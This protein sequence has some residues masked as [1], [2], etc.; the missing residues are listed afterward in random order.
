MEERGKR[1]NNGEIDDKGI[2]GEKTEKERKKK[3]K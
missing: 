2:N 1:G 3:G